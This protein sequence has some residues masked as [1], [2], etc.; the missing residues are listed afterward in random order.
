MGMV[1]IFWQM[2]PADD[3]CYHTR[4]PGLRDIDNPTSTHL[5]PDIGLTPL[6]EVFN[7]LRGVLRTPR[8]WVIEK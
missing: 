6:S 5:D 2:I 3:I 1:I 7:A 4:W 8:D